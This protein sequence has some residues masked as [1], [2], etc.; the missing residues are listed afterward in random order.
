[1]NLQHNL[2]LIEI[3]NKCISAC[4]HCASSCLEEKEVG[5]MVA[6]IKLD[7]DCAEICRTLVSFTTRGSLHAQHLLK[8]CAEICKACAIEAQKHS[9]MD[10]CKKCAEVC[11]ACAEVCISM[12]T[13]PV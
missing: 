4:N 11:L 3:L 5:M 2:N 1:M 13:T 8:E 9:Q 6:C 10:H 7:I 12:R